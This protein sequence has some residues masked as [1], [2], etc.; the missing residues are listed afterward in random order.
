M[1]PGHVSV[2]FILLK[3][4]IPVGISESLSK[5]PSNYS[6]VNCMFDLISCLYIL[7]G[8]GWGVNPRGQRC[9]G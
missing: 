6:V 5:L 1:I 2:G 9:E 8:K 7:P 4:G 3:R